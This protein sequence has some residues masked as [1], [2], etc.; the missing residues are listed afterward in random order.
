MEDIGGGGKIGLI[1]DNVDNEYLCRM[2]ATIIF[3]TT[4]L[5]VNRSRFFVYIEKFPI[6][7]LPEYYLRNV[8]MAIN[9]F[10]IKG[11]IVRLIFKFPK[12]ISLQFYNVF[13][14]CFRQC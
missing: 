8:V 7:P 13:I 11:L 4:E 12:T 3:S 2:G 9:C 6:I 14:C 5:L 10:S 1:P